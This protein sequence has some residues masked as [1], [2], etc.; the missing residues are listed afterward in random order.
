VAKTFRFDRAVEKRSLCLSACASGEMR[1]AAS[2]GEGKWQREEWDAVILIAHTWHMYVRRYTRFRFSRGDSSSLL[3]LFFSPLRLSLTF[4]GN[5]GCGSFALA[6][7]RAA[8][9]T[10]VNKLRSRTYLRFPSP[11]PSLPRHCLHGVQLQLHVRRARLR[12]MLLSPR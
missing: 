11:S 10:P 6:L 7:P 1:F 5:A 2:G 3:L 8:S 9:T 4:A 12:R